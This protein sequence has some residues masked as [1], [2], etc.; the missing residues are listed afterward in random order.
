MGKGRV[1][2][3]KK[4]D[5]HFSFKSLL[6]N[7]ENEHKHRKNSKCWMWLERFFLLFKV[8]VVLDNKDI[9]VLFISIYSAVK[10]STGNWTS[11]YVEHV[12]NHDRPLQ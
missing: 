9:Y 4:G 7:N 8:Q 11:S 1:N 10:G 5:F 3:R 2:I 6:F 12:I